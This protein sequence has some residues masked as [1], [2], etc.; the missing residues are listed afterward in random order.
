MRRGDRT[1]EADED[2]RTTVGVDLHSSR[3]RNGT[4]CKIYDVAGQVTLMLSYLGEALRVVCSSRT[5]QYA[6]TFYGRTRNRRFL[7]LCA[8]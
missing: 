1:P 3:L 8:A 4:E 2:R 6:W 7:C 5:G